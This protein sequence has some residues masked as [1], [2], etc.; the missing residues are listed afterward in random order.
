MSSEPQA[1]E[2]IVDVALIQPFP[3]TV[4]FEPKM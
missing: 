4:P 2:K 3:P 1:L